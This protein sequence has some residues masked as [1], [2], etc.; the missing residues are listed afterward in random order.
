MNNCAAASMYCPVPVFLSGRPRS[1]FGSLKHALRKQKTKTNCIFRRALARRL[2]FKGC[3]WNR[4]R[5]WASPLSKA[6]PA[7]PD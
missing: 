4:P 7:Q 6:G 3:L 1:H 5:W 2:L